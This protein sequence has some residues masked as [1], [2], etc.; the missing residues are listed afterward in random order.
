[1]GRHNTA[2]CSTIFYYVSWNLPFQRPP[3]GTDIDFGFP[4]EAAI[5]PQGP[6]GEKGERGDAGPPGEVILPPAP[7]P[8]NG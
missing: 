2:F 7:L 8:V 4:E 3:K 5:G 1:M 6:K